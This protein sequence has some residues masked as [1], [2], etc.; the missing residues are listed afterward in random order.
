[1]DDSVMIFSP[2]DV[3]YES[4]IGCDVHRDSIVCYSLAKAESGQW[5]QTKGVFKT[6]NDSLRD[7]V[8]WCNSH[9]PQ[10]I[11]MESTGIYWMPAYN[12]LEAANLPIALV[13]PCHVKRMDGK[14]TDM[15]DA[16]WL[17]K[18][19]VNGTFTASYIPSIEYRNLR[20]ECRNVTKMVDTLTSYKNRE[21]KLFASAGYK[22]SIFSDQFGASAMIAKQAILDGKSPAE[23]TAIVRAHGSKKVKATRK[24]M[25]EAF[26]GNMTET[27]RR[28]I[29]CLRKIYNEL[30]R[31]IAEEKK[32]LIDTVKALEGPAALLLKTIP[33]ISD[34]TATVVLIEI[35][36]V[37]NFLRAFANCDRFAAWTARTL[38]FKQSICQ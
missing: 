20:F 15:E 13:N 3:R 22:L 11:L 18:V 26:S 35:G 29:L 27:I 7:F 16:C 17:A 33:G 4:A 2:T 31:Q 12:S 32:F 1:M 8:N 6:T 34:W 38:P 24:E 25:L 30:E 23:V 9:N 37:V 14:K 28:T 36:G 19:A 10:K 21:T 5:V